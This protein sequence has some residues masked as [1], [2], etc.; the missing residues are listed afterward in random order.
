MCDPRCTIEPLDEMQSVQVVTLRY[1]SGQA[2]RDFAQLRS[3]LADGAVL[4]WNGPR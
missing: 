1:E 2:C 4:V 3:R